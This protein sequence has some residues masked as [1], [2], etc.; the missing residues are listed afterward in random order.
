[1]SSG[2]QTEDGP[3]RPRSGAAP[4]PTSKGTPRPT[5]G[6]VIFYTPSASRAFRHSLAQ[7]VAKRPVRPRR[8]LF[9]R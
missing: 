7:D 3:A 8:S 4:H 2:G 1:M 6:S 9:R 5:M